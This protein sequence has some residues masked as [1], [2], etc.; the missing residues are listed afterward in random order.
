MTSTIRPLI[1]RQRFASSILAK[2]TNLALNQT[3]FGQLV[4]V[5]RNTVQAWELA[6]AFPRQRNL[7]EL[8]AVLETTVEELLR[9]D[10]SADT[11]SKG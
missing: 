6:A 10:P 9:G 7:R 2:R 11:A 1:V 8:A 5:T 3:E 4:G